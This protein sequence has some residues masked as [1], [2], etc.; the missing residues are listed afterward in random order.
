MLLEVLRHQLIHAVI[1][2]DCML[3]IDLSVYLIYSRRVPEVYLYV[4]VQKPIAK[5]LL[6]NIC[7]TN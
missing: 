5:S 3:T 4:K 2:V 7:L 6:A 1:T